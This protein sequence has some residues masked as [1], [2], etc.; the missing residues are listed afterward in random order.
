MVE[1]KLSLILANFSKKHLNNIIK[2]GS[3]HLI[4]LRTAGPV[5]KSF[6]EELKICAI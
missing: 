6:A 2:R 5:H 1:S 4:I 3:S